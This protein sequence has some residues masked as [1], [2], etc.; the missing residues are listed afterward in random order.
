MPGIPLSSK[1]EDAGAKF[2]VDWGAAIARLKYRPQT[3]T[4]MAPHTFGRTGR[5]SLSCSHVLLFPI[6]LLLYFVRPTQTL[7][8]TFE[9]DGEGSL[10]VASGADN[11]VR[12]SLLTA[13]FVE[14]EQAGG[15]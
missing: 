15:T 8:I 14:G 1:P 9:G 7:T 11:R 12:R 2:L 5:S 6:G 10:I 3:Q 13:G 4:P